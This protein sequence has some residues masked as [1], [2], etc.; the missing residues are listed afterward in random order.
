MLLGLLALYRV[1][2]RMPTEESVRNIRLFTPRFKLVAG[3]VKLAQAEI[4]DLPAFQ[5]LL[6]IPSSAIWPPPL[7]DE[8]SQRHFLTSLE[9]TD[10]GDAG[11][12]LWFCIRREPRALVGVGASRAFRRMD[13]SRLATASWKRISGMATAR[14]PFEL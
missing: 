8:N 4:N 10:P 12:N 7:N 13:T 2:A 1:Q 11:W 3:I 14:R 6:E 5:A 9:K